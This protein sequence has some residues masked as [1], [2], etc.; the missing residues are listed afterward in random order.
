LQNLMS[1]RFRDLPYT[2]LNLALALPSRF[3]AQ[4]ALTAIEYAF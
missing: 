2:F 3:C 1:R 4:Y